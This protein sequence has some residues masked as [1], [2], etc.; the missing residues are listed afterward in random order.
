LNK[1]ILGARASTTEVARAIR[2]TASR[3]AT[4][5]DKVPS[6]LFKAGGDTVLDRMHRICVA[7]PLR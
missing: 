5:P 1:R 2:Q 6:E 7:T 4:G 3:K